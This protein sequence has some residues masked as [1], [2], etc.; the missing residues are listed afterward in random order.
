MVDN[1]KKQLE[2]NKKKEVAKESKS[3]KF[4]KLIDKRVS[5]AK[6]ALRIVGNCS[7][8]ANYEYTNEQVEIIF[9][10]L[11]DS[12][13]FQYNKY[14]KNKKQIDEFKLNA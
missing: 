14:Q 10:E 13:E 2:V 8:K 4:K 1:K 3:D 11:R 5:N 6:R 7:N 9:K 12:L